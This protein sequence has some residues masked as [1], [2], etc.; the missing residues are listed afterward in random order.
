MKQVTISLLLSLALIL[1]VSP[2]V[3]AKK[4]KNLGTTTSCTTPIEPGKPCICFEGTNQYRCENCDDPESECDDITPPAP[5]P[6]TFLLAGSIFLGSIVI[7]A[8]VYLGLKSMGPR[9]K[10]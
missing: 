6:P 9:T 2:L 3:N 8:G 1:L 10:G 5:P 4:K 7:A